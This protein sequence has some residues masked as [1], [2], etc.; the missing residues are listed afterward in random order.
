M[1]TFEDAV[2]LVRAAFEPGA[3]Q[4]TK[5]Q[6][7]TML[8]SLLAVL[9]TT[10]GAPLATPS[11]GAPPAAPANSPALPSATDRLGAFVEALKQHLPPEKLRQ[12]DSVPRLNIPLV[13][14]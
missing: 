10:P 2:K 9:E 1:G 4:A 14:L 8:R 5:Q 12:L 3:D 13:T 7:A 11:A 6:A